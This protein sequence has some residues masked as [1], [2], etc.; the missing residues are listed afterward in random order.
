[1]HYK[2]GTRKSK[3]AMAQTQE[4]LMR[5]K[6]AYPEDSFETVDLVTTGDREQEKALDAIGTK[7][8]FVDEI[9]KALLDGRISFAVHSMK[10]M[11]EAPA[12]GLI[13]SRAWKREDPRDVLI[14]RNAASLEMLP[15]G[16]LI[17][18]GSK[19]RAFQ[20]LKLRPDLRI[21]P[22]RGNVDTRIRRLQEGLPDG[23]QI[24]G[25]ILAAAGLK[26]LG[27]EAEITQYLKTTEMIPAP[28]Q[29]CLAIELRAE[30]SELLEKLNALCDPET[31]TL[32]GIEREFLKTIGGDCHLPIGAFA[33]RVTEQH[34]AEQHISE[35]ESECGGEDR[36]EADGADCKDS[37]PDCGRDLYRL[38]ALYGNADGSRLA[39]V[40]CE[41]PAPEIQRP[42]KKDLAAGSETFAADSEEAGM[43]NR[44][45]AGMLNQEE[46]DMLKQEM[47]SQLAREAAEAIR[48]K[49]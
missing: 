26:R 27:L 18:T 6:A 3:L 7:G 38:T 45:D 40:V 9:E 28:A 19:R 20:L 1:M 31:D 22:I 11:P 44:E 2:V 34:V 12:E 35:Q 25:I 23:T 39:S 36:S 49:L 48:K 41:C 21:V 4:V 16:A 24:D 8:V 37:C 15:A 5:L 17:A 14:L 13:F 33:E 46:A 29:G 42:E 47:I 32:I 10:D 43:L 30:D